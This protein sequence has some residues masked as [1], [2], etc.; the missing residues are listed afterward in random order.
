MIPEAEIFFFEPRDTEEKTVLHRGFYRAGLSL[1]TT[2]LHRWGALTNIHMSQSAPASRFPY[3]NLILTP[4]LFSDQIQQLTALYDCFIVPKQES[5][6]TCDTLSLVELASMTPSWQA[7]RLYG[8]CRSLP[9]FVGQI[10][11]L[12][13]MVVNL[14]P[15]TLE[16]QHLSNKEIL[17]IKHWR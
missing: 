13:G 5:L 2:L 6:A 4:N 14:K 15:L 12:H 8:A 10:F 3:T 11:S 16:I 17:N 7:G 9:S 1:Y